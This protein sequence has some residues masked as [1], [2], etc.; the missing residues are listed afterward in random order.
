MAPSSALHGDVGAAGAPST[1][2]ATFFRLA[3]AVRIAAVSDIHGDLATLE[4]AL[5]DMARRGADVTVYLRDILSGPLQPRETDR[6]K[7]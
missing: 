2:A 5:A 1:S 4:A 3:G 6:E 7:I